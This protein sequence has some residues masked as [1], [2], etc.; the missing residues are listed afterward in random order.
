MLCRQSDDTGS[1]ALSAAAEDV[2]QWLQAREFDSIMSTFAQPLT[3]P[4]SGL[5][6]HAI[7]IRAHSC[8][9]YLSCPLVSIVFAFIMP[10]HAIP[11]L[12]FMLYCASFVCVPRPVHAISC[13]PF[14]VPSI[15]P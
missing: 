12:H 14:N 7:T 4:L 5:P 1:F 9:A 3:T 6:T 8:Q 13:V 10:I 15:M 11:C 2:A